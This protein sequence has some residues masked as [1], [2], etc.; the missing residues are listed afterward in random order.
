MRSVSSAFWLALQQEGIQ[1][2]ELLEF[3]TALQVF[4]WTVANKV[5][6]SSGFEWYPFPGRNVNGIEESNDLGVN[7]T[8]FVMANTGT[9]LPAVLVSNNFD[10]AS[11]IVRRVLVNSP[12][13]GN[14]TIYRGRM[15]D[16]AYNRDAITG[17][18]RN[19]WNSADVQWPYYTYM[20]TCVWRFGGV[21][22]GVDASSFTVRSLQLLSSTE[23]RTLT[24]TAG[25]L[26][27]Y[28]NGHF[29]R[30][31]V[32]FKTGQNS[33]QL[34]SI[35][36]HSGSTLALFHRLPYAVSS[37]DIIEIFPGCRKRIITD[38]LSKFNNTGRALAFPWI[39]KQEQ[40]F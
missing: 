16:F 34:R 8:D 38:C 7:V 12:D 17:Q 14:V 4:R 31:R 30:G 18:L 32:T 28:S 10:H 15:G 2:T 24:T 20:D 13:L 36:V 33:G 22:C 27:A 3:T 37:G 19:R 23:F 29:D 25:S 26:S 6:V 11:L 21:G 9:V 40:A 35:L 1:L 39:P 5:M